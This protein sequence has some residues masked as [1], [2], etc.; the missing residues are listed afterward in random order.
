MAS[1]NTLGLSGA[2][3]GVRGAGTLQKSGGDRLGTQLLRQRNWVPLHLAFRAVP[4]SAIENPAPGQWTGTMPY[5]T[6]LLSAKD[7]IQESSKNEIV[8]TI[9]DLV[10]LIRYEMVR[11]PWSPVDAWRLPKLQS[12]IPGDLFNAVVKQSWPLGEDYHGDLTWA[13]ILFSPERWL[14]HYLVDFLDHEIPS[15]IWDV[16]KLFQECTV[17]WTRLLGGV[18]DDTRYVRVMGILYDALWSEFGMLHSVLVTIAWRAVLHRVTPYATPA[19]AAATHAALTRG[20]LPC[21]SS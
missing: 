11:A 10:Q 7:W 8:T 6:G 14:P 18:H 21:T 5:M 13:N 19:I 16:A 2:T 12:R 9:T 1:L 3:F 20:M 17:G 15:P 4:V